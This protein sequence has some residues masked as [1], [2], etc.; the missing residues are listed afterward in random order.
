MTADNPRPTLLLVHGAWHGSWCWDRVRPLLED[1]GWATRTVDLPSAGGPDA[2]LH[3][4]SRAVLAEMERIDGPVVVVA[5]SYGGAPVS[6][7]LASAPGVAHA[8]YVAAFQLDAGESLLGQYGAPL[9]EEPHGVQP[10][11]DDPVH[12][13][14]GGVPAAEAEEAARRLVPQSTRSFAETLTGAG[15]HTVPSTYV[16]CEQDRALPLQNQEAMAAR[17]GA[18]HRL[19]SHH[20]PFLSAPGEFAALL[21]KIAL[22]AAG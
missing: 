15:W 1:D 21:A 8:V 7:A 12:L 4:D 20:S 2:G 18:V 5:H 14:Y 17:A 10:V 3:D 6:Q 22:E 13:F 16:V 19:A 11:P 9:P